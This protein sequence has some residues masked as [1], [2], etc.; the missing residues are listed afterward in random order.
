M[1]LG[2]SGARVEGAEGVVE[3]STGTDGDSQRLQAGDS[4]SYDT[5]GSLA[6]ISAVDPARVGAWRSGL[7]SFHQTPLAEL[8]A[9][10]NR[11][12][13]KPIRIADPRLSEVPVSGV[14]E[15]F[16]DTEAVLRAVEQSLSAKAVDR[17]S[18]I[19]LLLQ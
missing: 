6:D 7:R 1:R 3:V 11:Y 18:S 16:A 9:D 13:S 14:F 4:V 19:D 15:Q 8:V 5:G 17:G 2:R 12:S 10:L